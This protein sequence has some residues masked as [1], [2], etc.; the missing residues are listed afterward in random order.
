MTRRRG[1]TLEA[2][3]ALGGVG[4]I[5]RRMEGKQ[6]SGVPPGPSSAGVSPGPSSEGVSPD[7]SSAGVS[8]GPS[9]AGVQ[10]EQ[11]GL[12]HHLPDRAQ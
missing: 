4:N 1:E 8:P 9:S 2:T 7:P 5:R 12:G 3:S 11:K 6:V 10:V